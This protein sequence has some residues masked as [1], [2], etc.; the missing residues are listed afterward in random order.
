M[1]H[2]GLLHE[3]KRKRATN[4]SQFCCKNTHATIEADK[5]CWLFSKWRATASLTTLKTTSIGFQI[6]PKSLT[7]TMPNFDWKS[8]KIDLFENLLQRSIKKN[9]QLTEEVKI[10]F[11]II[12]LLG[13]ELQ[14]LNNITSPSKWN[15]FPRNLGTRWIPSHW[16][17]PNFNIID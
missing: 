3:N 7:T 8:K 5:F 12:F 16:L 4:Q 1:A 13:D 11:F 10:Y 14:M 15:K 9:I 17:R 2:L 6:C